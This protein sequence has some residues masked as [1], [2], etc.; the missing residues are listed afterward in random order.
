[1]LN[2]IAQIFA[3]TGS[4]VKS[5][6]ER[7]GAAIAAAVGIAGVV[8]VLVGVLS[9]AEGFRR[10]MTVTG[11]PDVAIVLRDGMLVWPFI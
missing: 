4:F 6:P 2:W 9:I 5:L 1:M 11:M 10:A 7:R 3:I 8:T